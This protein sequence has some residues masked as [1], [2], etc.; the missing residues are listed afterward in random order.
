MAK[1]PSINFRIPVAGNLGIAALVAT[2]T[3]TVFGCGTTT[4]RLATE[5]LLIS[6]AV[7]Q[8]VSDI[9]FSYLSNQDIFMETKYLN[10]VQ[11]TGFANTDYIIS[12]IRE[13]L[14][15]AGC[16]I[17]EERKDATIIVEPRVGALGT[18]G[19]EV[20]YGLPQTNQYTT[21][22]S[23]LSGSPLVPAIP[24]ISFG[25]SDQHQG[26]AKIVL[27]AYD[28]ETKI[29]L[30]QS[31]VKKSES[32]SRNTWVL[33]AGP[34]QKGTIHDG[35][36][37]A[38]RTLGDVPPVID[39]SGEEHVLADLDT[40]EEPTDDEQP[41]AEPKLDAPSGEPV[42]ADDTSTQPPTRN[43]DQS[44]EFEDDFRIR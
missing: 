6:D 27:F 15:A 41:G 4:Q 42:L 37:F 2:V 7:D 28:R 35:Y 16:R 10:G 39:A 22:A 19:H 8:A 20:T 1:Y 33:G 12:A 40:L 14:A 5:Q 44:V 38:G 26:I 29:A 43:A 13:Q 9:D 17:Q 24:E 11:G 30:W 34:F 31:G 36:R 25:R 32:S 18:D 21:A 3:L 23:A